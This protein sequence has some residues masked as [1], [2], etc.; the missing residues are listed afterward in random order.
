[1]MISDARRER[2]QHFNGAKPWRRDSMRMEKWKIETA[3]QL[4]SKSRLENKSFLDSLSIS[5]Q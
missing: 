5:W 2:D 4:A 1:M 3:E